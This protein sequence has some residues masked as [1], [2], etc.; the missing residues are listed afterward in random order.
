MDYL[1]KKVDAGADMIITQMFFDASTYGAFLRECRAAGIT[2]PV[3]PG[4]MLVQAAGGFRKMTTMCKTRVPE[5][6]AKAVDTR[7]S[8]D[9]ELKSYG[10]DLGVE[11]SHQLLKYGAP[12]LHF[13]T[14]NL[15][16]STLAIADRVAAD[17]AKTAKSEPDWLKLAVGVAAVAGLF[18]F[19]LKKRA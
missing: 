6:V 14:L 17:R 19:A 16:K 7:A 15:E 2:V 18:A 3:V 1:K 8:D 5:A 10:V 4:I 12:G 13:Y 9:A 11:M